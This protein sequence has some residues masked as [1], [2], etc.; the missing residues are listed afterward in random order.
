MSKSLD[1]SVNEALVKYF[2]NDINKVNI[3]L[4]KQY[5]TEK[6]ITKKIAKE[7]Y[8]LV[9][10]QTFN[11]KGR[12]NIKKIERD[13]KDKKGELK[14]LNQL[15]RECKTQKYKYGRE[16]ISMK[17]L[18][19]LIKRENK[20]SVSE[21]LEL[22]PT[23]SERDIGIK[24]TRNHVFE[25]LWIISYLRNLDDIE[26]Q[27]YKQFY[28][29]LEGGE[30]QSY[31]DVINGPVNSGNQGGIA[32]IYF[33]LK[34]NDGNE[35]GGP[36]K[37]VQKVTCGPSKIGDFPVPHCENKT[38]QA[39]DKYLFSSKYY[40]KTKSVG[41]Y[42]I[43]EIFTEAI[44]KGVNK[45][46]II[47]L[48]Q[49][50]T[51]LLN[52]MDTSNKSLSNLCHKIYD[53][54][55]LNNHYKQ[56][57]YQEKNNSLDITTKK[58]Q[59]RPRFHQDYFIEYSCGCMKKYKTK[60]FVWGAVPRSGKSFMIG[61]LI[62]KVKPK[63]VLLYLGAITET[64]QQF[65]EMFINYGDFKE[66]EIHDLQNKEIYNKGKSKQIIIFSQEKNRMDVKKS[67]LPKLMLDTFLEKDKLIFFDEIHQGSGDGSL[68]EE[69][70]KTIVFDN[71]YKAFIMV[72]ATFAKPYLKYINK[73]KVQGRLIQWRYDDI[74]N[75]KTIHT[76]VIDD[77]GEELFIT[78]EKIKENILDEDDGEFKL[79]IFNSLLEQCKERGIDFEKLAKQYEIYPELIV[80]TPIIDE[81]VTNDFSDIIING[82]I[83]V[84]KVF[85]PL[86][87]KNPSDIGKSRKYIEYIRKYIYEKYI[88]QTLNK[89][90]T[91][92]KPHSEIWFLPTIFRSEKGE[93]DIEKQ[94]GIDGKKGIPG[95][96]YMTQH[97]STLLL[98]NPWFRENYCIIILHS[99]GFDNSEIQ[100]L[101]AQNMGGKKLKW[102]GTDVDVQHTGNSSCIST[103][104][105]N[106][107][108]V[109]DCILKQE[110]CAKAN[111]KSLIILTGKMLRLGVSLPC[112]D[113][114][115]HMDPIQSVDTIYQSMFRV[116]TERKGKKYGI[117]IDMLT[118]RQI[119]F[120]YEYINYISNT[121]NDLT[122]EKKMKKLLEKL[123]LWNF[124]GINFQQADDYQMLYNKLMRDFSLDDINR[125]TQNVKK[126]D[127]SEVS[128]LVRSFNEDMING[129]HQII[130]KLNINYKTVKKPKIKKKLKD[131]KGMDIPPNDYREINPTGNQLPIKVKANPELK[132][133][134][135]EVSSFLNDMITLFALFSTDTYNK[136]IDR[137]DI[138]IMIQSFF[139]NE[140]DD[141]YNFCDNMDE[142]DFSVIDC[143][144]MNTIKNNIPTKEL[145]REYNVMKKSLQEFFIDILKE[146]S[147]YKIFVTNIEDMKK[148]KKS[149][150]DIKEIKPCSDIFIKDEKVLE[151]IRKRLSVREE[152]KNLYGEVFTPIELI[153]D[154]F[155]HIPDEVWTNPDLKWL[156][157]ANGIGNFPVVAYYKLMDS[158]KGKIPQ[159]AKRSKHIIKNML[160]MVELNPVNVR[161]C[162]KIFKII[163]PTATPNIVK[164]DF[165][166]FD[167]KNKFG[168]EKFDVIMGNPP[169]QMEQTGK[170]KGGYGGRTIW[171]RFILD[172]MEMLNIKGFLCFINPPDWRKPPNTAP[173][174]LW[175]LFKSKN[176]LYVRILSDKNIFDVGKRIDCYI[177]NNDKYNGDTKIIDEK[178]NIN[179]INVSK[180]NFLPNYNYSIFGNIITTEGKGVDVIYHSS[181]YDHRNLSKKK[182][183]KFTV[184]VIRTIN[185]SGEEVRYGDNKL[186]EQFVPKVICSMGQ[187]TFPI[188][189]Y[190]GNYGMGEI[191]FGIP[192]KSEKHGDLL[193]KAL[194]SEEFIEGI[195]LS[196]K[197]GTYQTD[198]RMFKYFKPDFYKYFLSKSKSPQNFN[199]KNKKVIHVKQKTK[200]KRPINTPVVKVSSKSSKSPKKQPKKTMKKSK[201]SE[202]HPEP[203]CLKDKPRL[204]NGCCY[205]DKKTKKG[206]GKRRRRRRKTSRK[207][208]Y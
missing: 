77:N 127:L 66:Y 154:M 173:T 73:D 132:Q 55:D 2:D 122:T 87:K 110:A 163:D 51:E 117:F 147:F 48:V 188:N 156:D 37:I 86:M 106:S 108:S 151:I 169:F 194:N 60:N 97:F 162:K 80:S 83:N 183:G 81:S 178:G 78:Y 41:D 206:G 204:K 180:W 136:H 203:P 61:G 135:D 102:N 17:D 4:L 198:Y 94:T 191:T 18:L 39:Q 100:F 144:L 140:I 10:K 104:C 174:S 23:T 85:K 119:S 16:N 157:P 89:G 8:H 152:E 184:P 205:K 22:F 95:F 64:K 53:I 3:K 138:S 187:Q 82:N 168:I 11:V 165:L 84:D 42:D 103:T 134:Y 93:E 99:V 27:K 40:S 112:V 96:R 155:S 120:M 19:I 76:S 15:L 107:K 71:P 125:F 26:K 13:I 67:N 91:L 43:A 14:E 50:K 201:C 28:K 199:V 109:K 146:D 181:H 47:L 5:V 98:E 29:S 159:E 172:S 65:V 170:R 164:H 161:V 46:N 192:I 123:L 35:T 70:L 150:Q 171:H 9:S 36:E 114:A 20:D 200:K 69:M 54:N 182:H 7:L 141:I 24:V 195:I 145:S 75:M 79:E 101:D 63:C 74:Q 131:R 115:L 130:E 12:C 33:E 6:K 160:Y 179:N 62:A 177:L 133:K 185:K 25:A 113:I 166:T 124:N 57:L 118:T 111:G 90:S 207:R 31:E 189:D 105:A 72:T 190:N 56:I 52:K 143:H 92:L 44:S 1:K 68:Q 32:D 193:V 126:I 30:I 167:S 49:D 121:K 137:K 88:I 129:F 58:P 45:F 59:I 142:K 196:T 176:L 175:N 139:N 34:G 21:F 149:S 128:E 202:L 148:L 197:W 158:L 208:R 153:C 38:I 116:L 186:K